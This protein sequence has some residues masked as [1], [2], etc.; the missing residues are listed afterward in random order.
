MKAGITSA[1][2]STLCGLHI[3]IFGGNVTRVAW[4]QVFIRVI[5][6]LCTLSPASIRCEACQVSKIQTIQKGI[7]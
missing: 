1:T 6:I 3:R 2:A 4:L 5:L 7:K